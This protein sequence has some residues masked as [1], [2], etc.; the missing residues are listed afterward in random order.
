MAVVRSLHHGSGREQGSDT[1]STRPDASASST[2]NVMGSQLFPWQY[3]GLR[4]MR[5]RNLAPSTV[6]SREPFYGI[7]IR[8]PPAVFR[9]CSVGWPRAARNDESQSQP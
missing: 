1:R 6:M 3:V 8:Q 5:Q 2:A 4:R 7:A 9:H